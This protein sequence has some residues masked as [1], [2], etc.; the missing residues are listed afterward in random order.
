MGDVK[1][2]GWCRRVGDKR[3]IMIVCVVPAIIAL[4]YYSVFRIE[5]DI[6]HWYNV[7]NFRLELACYD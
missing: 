7:Y 6:L 5:F 4:L 2:R 1:L 3:C